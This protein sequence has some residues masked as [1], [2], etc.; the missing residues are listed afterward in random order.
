MSY[1]FIYFIY[2]LIINRL[3]F[4]W[5]LPEKESKKKS[6]L[7]EKESKKKKSIIPIVA[8]VVFLNPLLTLSWMIKD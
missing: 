5:I 1:I 8:Y 6:I 4:L 3:L 2:I 7:P